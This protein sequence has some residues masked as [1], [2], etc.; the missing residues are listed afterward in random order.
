[1]T[2]DA[3]PLASGTVQF[4]PEEGQGL[5]VGALITDGAY[6]LPNPPGLPPGRYRVS[7]SAQGGAVV[8]PGVAPD[9]DLGRPGVKDPVPARYNLETT[10]RA[11]VTRGGSNTFPFELTSKPDSAA[12][13]RKGL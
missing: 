2:L 6:R 10:L 7:I 5:A 1:V 8:Q 13:G 9:M 3:K 12:A 11:E 4:T